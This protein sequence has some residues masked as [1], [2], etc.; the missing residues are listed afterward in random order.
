MIET[1]MKE[2]F[3]GDK[4]ADETSRQRKWNTLQTRP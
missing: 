4:E 1:E 3:K 2:E